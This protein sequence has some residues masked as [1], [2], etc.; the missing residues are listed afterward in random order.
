VLTIDVE[1]A[2]GNLELKAELPEFD[3]TTVVIGP[4][5]AGK[6]TLLKLVLGALTPSRGR[7]ELGDSLLFSSERRIDVPM[8][9][10]R[11]GY[12]PQSYALFPHMTV[13]QNVEF[14][15]R[16]VERSER[17]DRAVKL[18]EELGVGH[19]AD[20]RTPSLSGGESQRVALAR[21]L[22]I[23]PHALLL[24]E[25]MAALDT[26]ARRKVRRFL[27]ERLQKIGIPTLVVTHDAGDI[28]SLADR[29]VVLEAGKL[30]QVGSPTEVREHPAS[31]F[32]REFLAPAD[33]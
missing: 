20:R 10:R 2:V 4:N 13:R 15:I 27:G 16:D 23:R 28:G 8:E 3:K 9:D 26:A 12:V 32:V 30:L 22:A 11:L 25:P 6:S 19:L 18:L 31:E 14:G 5:G 17:R 33:D 21:A 7:I 1:V 29:V 24:D